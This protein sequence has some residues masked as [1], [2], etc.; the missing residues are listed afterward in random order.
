MRAFT[1]VKIEGNGPLRR[2]LNHMVE[3]YLEDFPVGLG[4][5][6]SAHFA[7]ISIRRNGGI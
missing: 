3:A 7:V 1:C 4:E 5:G 6:L 2:P